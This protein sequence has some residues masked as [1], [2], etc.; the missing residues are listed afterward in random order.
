MSI[1]D[2]GLNE[3]VNLLNQARCERD[4]ARQ[5]A[6]RAKLDFETVNDHVHEC[7]Q[8]LLKHGVEAGVDGSVT[9]GIVQLANERDV[10]RADLAIQYRALQEHITALAS[11]R[12]EV[13]EARQQRDALADALETCRRELSC[14]ER[15]DTGERVGAVTEALGEARAALAKAGRL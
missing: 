2:A 6:D 3:V 7:Q 8:E 1:P 10:L 5:A 4:E 15:T 14:Y 13:D 11:S 9:V 12:Q